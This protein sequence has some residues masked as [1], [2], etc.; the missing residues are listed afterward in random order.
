V[1]SDLDQAEAAAKVAALEPAAALNYAPRL[2]IERSLARF[3]RSPIMS[4]TTSMAGS[5]DRQEGNGEALA[6]PGCAEFAAKDLS[7][8][9]I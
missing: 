3:S 6:S 5:I 9:H 2:A 7:L 4:F 1:R 8:I